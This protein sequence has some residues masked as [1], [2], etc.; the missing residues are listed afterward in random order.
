MIHVYVVFEEIQVFSLI[1]WTSLLDVII[2]FNT[3]S[4]WYKNIR[5]SQKNAPK[6]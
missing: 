4:K 6:I 3:T 1:M 2:Y 5:K